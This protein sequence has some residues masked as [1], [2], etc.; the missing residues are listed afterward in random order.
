MTFKLLHILFLNGLLSFSNVYGQQKDSLIE[1]A[2]IL[3]RIDSLVTS[4]NSNKNCREK[5]SEGEI[6][7]DNKIIGGFSTYYLTE[8]Q[9]NKTL[10]IRHQ[11]S[12][13][14]YYKTTFYYDT[15]K[16][17]FATVVIEDWNS[18]NVKV[19]YNAKY[20]FQNNSLLFAIDEDKKYSTA[21]DI[22]IKGQKFLQK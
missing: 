6:M 14:F 7:K 11:S 2:T 21:S 15:D 3:N 4:I 20:Y 5:I 9:T 18:K 13:D 10:R 8:E 17:I 12:T 1:N 22:L 19:V 16:I